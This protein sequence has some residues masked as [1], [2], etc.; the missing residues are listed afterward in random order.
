MGKNKEYLVYNE[1]LSYL[2]SRNVVV[3]D[4]SKVLLRGMLE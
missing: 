2:Q 1:T 3:D 4:N